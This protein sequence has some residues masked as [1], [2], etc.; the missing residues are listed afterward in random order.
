[1]LS[2]VSAA[3]PFSVRDILSADQE[4]NSM[5][6]YQ[7]QTNLQN[8]IGTQMHNDFYN[9]YGCSVQD[10]HSWD[11][12]KVKE[13]IINDYNGYGDINPVQQLSQIVPPYQE[14]SVV[15]DGV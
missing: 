9:V 10:N 2:T 15:E 6:C 14:N 12:D 1:M 7:S 3:T 5:H 11:V 8:H 4:A 13:E